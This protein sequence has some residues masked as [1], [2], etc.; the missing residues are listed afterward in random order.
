MKIKEHL[1]VFGV[2]AGL[3]CSCVS[4]KQVSY[5]QDMGDYTQ[6][7]LENKYEAV[8][9][10]YDELIIR[11]S[12][13]DEELSKPFNVLGGSNGNYSYD[14]SSNYGMGY[15][16]DV[17]GNIDFPV[18]GQ[19]HVGGLT[20]LQIQ[21]KIKAILEEGNLIKEPF[22]YVRFRNY[23]IFFLTTDGGRSITI[24]NER[25]TFLEALALYGELDIYS[26]RNK[27]G[28]LREENGK[29]VMHY[30]D[31][32]S[33]AVF[34]DPY[35]LL[36]QNDFIVIEKRG[37]KV[38]FANFADWTSVIAMVSSVATMVLMFL[39]FGGISPG[40]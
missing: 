26:K 17:N 21:E 24:P 28:V 12:A 38:F 4:T 15:L 16:V 2:A 40:A 19:I 29:M 3:L 33:S 7:E 31:P 6:I 10:P 13:Y 36:K 25:C 37:Y 27:M 34:N 1:I 35:Y 18:I 22:V 20:R 30:L 23:K 14:T 39:S 5:L 9:S 8:V 11:V 32:R